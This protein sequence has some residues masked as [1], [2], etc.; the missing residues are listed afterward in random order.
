MAKVK[1]IILNIAI[2]PDGSITEK[3]YPV[4]KFVD[5]GFK[6]E[7][8]YSNDSGSKS[9]LNHNLSTKKVLVY[10]DYQTGFEKQTLNGW[11]LKE[12]R[13]DCIKRLINIRKNSYS[14]QILAAQAAL[15]NFVKAT[16]PLLNLTTE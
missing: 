10:A 9:S 14:K 4:V 2:A 13:N 7:T 12:N 5:S 16:E 15:D 6:Q 8:I 3:E 11:C 1:Q